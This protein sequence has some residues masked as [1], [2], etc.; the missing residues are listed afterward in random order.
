VNA[1]TRS[2][3][4]SEPGKSADA[5]VR[6]TRSFSVPCIAPDRSRR[7]GT[8]RPST[9]PRNTT[10][11]IVSSSLLRTWNSQ[12]RLAPLDAGSFQVRAFYDREVA[13]Q[14][15]R[16]LSGNGPLGDR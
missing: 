6:Y 5:V 13:A 2:E 8:V 15:A 10:A 3:S 4:R 12:R 1:R 9:S 16:D 11:S 14:A 7:T